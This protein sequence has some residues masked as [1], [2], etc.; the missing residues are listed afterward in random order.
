MNVIKTWQEL[1]I[2]IDNKY[3]AKVPYLPLLVSG[4]LLEL[5]LTNFCGVNTDYFQLWE[6]HTI[7][8]SWNDGRLIV[9][10]LLERII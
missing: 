4:E 9:F 5:T 8:T 7:I 10:V 6:V 3:R 1:E 2:V